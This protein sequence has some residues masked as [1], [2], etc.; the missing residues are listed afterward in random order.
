MPDVTHPLILCEKKIA[1]HSLEVPNQLDLDDTHTIPLLGLLTS[2]PHHDGPTS[3]QD[4]KLLVDVVG[5]LLD[6]GSLPRPALIT[7]AKSAE[8]HYTPTTEAAYLEEAVLDMV[9]NAT[10][11]K[12]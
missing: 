4:A 10:F 7:V 6:S 1:P 11:I 3:Q 12:L 5:D 2:L 8:D 9:K